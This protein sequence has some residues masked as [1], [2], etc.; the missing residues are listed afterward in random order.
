M[1]PEIQGYMTDSS[2]EA[3]GGDPVT[4]AI[5][6]AL[7]RRLEGLARAQERTMVELVREAVEIQF[8]D[9]AAHARVRL[10]DRLARLEAGLEGLHGLE[11][12]EDQI[13]KD[14][15]RTRLASSSPSRRSS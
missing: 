4:L 11:D 14:A 15:R 12:L 8:G 3:H 6:A 1:T 10:L 13:R 9:D 2:A 7:Y 5:P